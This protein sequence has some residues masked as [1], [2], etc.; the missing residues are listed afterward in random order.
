MDKIILSKCFN[1]FCFHFCT[2]II[3]IKSPGSDHFVAEMVETVHFVADIISSS[4]VFAQVFPAFVPFLRRLL[5]QGGVT[6]CF[7][8]F[9]RR[10]SAQIMAV[11]GR[12]FGSFWN[13]YENFA[14][15]GKL[16]NIGIVF[17]STGHADCP[18]CTL[19]YT[20]TF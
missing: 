13:L 11:S 3:L 18:S 20:A 7:F 16:M 15:R 19:W 9:S 2:A 12:L 14:I 1:L 4:T 5:S 8:S 17:A 10:F 6:S